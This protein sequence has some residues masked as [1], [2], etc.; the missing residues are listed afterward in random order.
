MSEKIYE[1]FNVRM[2]SWTDGTIKERAR[3]KMQIWKIMTETDDELYRF[4]MIFPPTGRAI[5]I[6]FL[7]CD[8]TEDLVVE[9]SMARDGSVRMKLVGDTDD[10]VPVAFVFLSENA[11]LSDEHIEENLEH[12]SVGNNYLPELLLTYQR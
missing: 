2:Y 10:L 9:K 4:R 11:S 7:P 12:P 6:P 1:Q 8:V 5:G 3:G